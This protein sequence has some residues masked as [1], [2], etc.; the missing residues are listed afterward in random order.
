M[1][2]VKLAMG[3]ANPTV[4]AVASNTNQCVDLAQRMAVAGVTVGVLPEQVLGGYCPEDLVQWR[5]FVQAQWQGLGEF[6]RRTA[7]TP[8]VFVVGL[9][10][11]HHGHLFNCAAVVH[12]GKVL[13][14]V[15]KEKLPTYNVFYEARTLSHGWPGMDE[16]VEGV[17][18]GDL[19]FR[20][21][22]GAL[23]AEVCEDVWSPDGPMRRRCYAGAELVVNASAS[24]YRMGVVATRREMLAT[25]SADNQCTLLYGNCV[26][27]NDGLLFDGGGSVHQNGRLC[28]EA[29]RFERG[30]F[31]TVV[32]LDRTARL[33]TENTTWRTDCLQARQHQGPLPR[34]V[35]APGATANT[36]ALTYPHPAHRS[37]F[38]P[39]PA[40]AR[41]P[42]QDF[43]E[44]LLDALGMGIRDYWEKTGAF[45][46][47]GLALSGG[48]DSLLTL[49]VAWRMLQTKH[50]ALDDAARKAATAA[51]L[52]AFFMPTRYS[53]DH[54]ARSAETI[55]REL[56][57]PLRVVSIEEAFD[58]EANA[59]RTM[60]GGELTGVTMQNIQA[61]LRSLRM[62]NW[63][64]TSGML[65]LQTGNMSEKAMGYTTIGGDLEGA[66][67][68]LANVPKTVVIYLLEY[69]LQTHGF[70]G[71]RMT[72]SVP[73]GPELAENQKGEE[74]LMP[75]AVLD[76]CFYL[77]AAEK[78]SPQEM[79]RVL[80]QIFPEHAAQT[81][82]LVQ[83]FIRNFTNN[84]Y[85]WVQAP[86]SLHVG[87]LD[88]DRERA[89]QMPVVE[90][91]EWTKA[92]S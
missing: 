57:V 54:S 52:N 62:W 40:P 28:L 61:R 31:T 91:P 89:L 51:Q 78:L 72:L 75:F 79:E 55:C 59:A 85:K 77:Y 33:R 50:A 46:G 12:H 44:D 70:E 29:P 53:S 18:F 74:E 8:T 45:K 65:F 68:V 88:L 87:N 7:T 6:A 56:G 36:D 80:P 39:A 76:T 13:G 20:F 30:V 27:A 66:L 64:N 26:G 90:S 4:G 37:F 63:A 32:D 24:P 86:L 49:L 43:C 67:A 34:T 41:T 1:R 17:P 22:F 81:T 5:A 92:G 82:E 2:L 38:L 35:E 84:I 60:V 3:C 58:R 69:L 73:A 9:A 25:R 19:V 16:V 15:P 42:Q 83:K 23:S 47:L 71:I 21:A 48:R 11:A 14:L 10:V